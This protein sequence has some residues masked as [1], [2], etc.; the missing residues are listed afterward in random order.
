MSI[1]LCFYNLTEKYLKIFFPS[2]FREDGKNHYTLAAEVDDIDRLVK[3]QI[4][5]FWVLNNRRPNP[6]ELMMSINNI[7]APQ[8]TI[9]R[10][11]GVAIDQKFAFLAKNQCI[12]GHG[13][14]HNYVNLLCHFADTH[15]TDV[16]NLDLDSSNN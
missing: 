2:D 3:F 1:T 6:E 9:D 10:I 5:A 11:K 4:F 12:C 15:L 13:P 14:C 16:S 8:E 7:N